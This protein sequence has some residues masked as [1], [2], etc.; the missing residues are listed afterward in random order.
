MDNKTIAKF[1]RLALK[2][3]LGAGDITTTALV[4]AGL[5]VEASIVMR[6]PAIVCG[7]DFIKA[8]FRQLDRKAVVSFTHADGA[9]VKAGDEVAR[10][11]GKAR[12]ILSGERVALNF[13]G[14]LSGISTLTRL[15]ADE[16]R[17]TKAVILDTR[18]TTAGMRGLDRYAVRMGGGINHRFDLGEMV[19]VKD[20]HRLLCGGCGELAGMVRDLREKTTRPI[21][22]EVDTLMELEDVLREPPE[23]VLLDNMTVEQLRKAIKLV[24][25]VPLRAR[26]LLEA[27]G[28]VNIRNVRSVALTGVD[29]ISIGAL[30]HSARCMD[31]SLELLDSTKG[32]G[33]SKA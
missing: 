21:E 4:P 22:V 19:L 26:P 25:A 28:G 27:S 31:V 9:R 32:A 13:L 1:V 15:F 2:E 33:C 17:G 6:E 5:V 12:A 14:R 8:T 3:D 16:V 11:R 30:T 18:K 7:L 20:N 23:M 24:A 29:R 10:V